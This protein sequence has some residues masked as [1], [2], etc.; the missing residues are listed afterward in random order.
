MFVYIVS[1]A[2]IFIAGCFYNHKIIFNRKHFLV[3]AF[4]ILGTI[5]AIRNVSVGCDTAAYMSMYHGMRLNIDSRI[6]PGFRL[7]CQILNGI[8]SDERILL[9]V[10]GYFCMAA[11]CIF[12]YKYSE[13]PLLS[14]MLFLMYNYFFSMMNLMRQYIALAICILALP[15]GKKHKGYYCLFVLLAASFHYTA[16]VMLIVCFFMNGKNVSRKKII[17]IIIAGIIVYFMLPQIY[18]IVTEIMPQYRIYYNTL[19]MSENYF[20]AL[21][22]S[23]RIGITLCLAWVLIQ[24][25]SMN[26]DFIIIMLCM[27]FIIQIFG[28]RINL[29]ARIA[30]YF[31]VF[32]IIAIPNAIKNIKKRDIKIAV[33]GGVAAIS[34]IYFII[35]AVFRPGW[36]GAIP[37]EFWQK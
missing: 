27:A 9:L 30:Q 5:A 36:H 23:M 37:Y 10:T 16:I 2:G 15:L 28:T 21:I 6:E 12:I 22:E 34:L 1:F 32:E 25:D 13:N 18:K 8:S 17:H 31:S 4:V 33:T 29:L 26:A 20:G 11:F 14:V 3:L 19:Y 7:L 35:I 24:K